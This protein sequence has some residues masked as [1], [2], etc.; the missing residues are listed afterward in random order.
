MK[1][2]DGAVH[3]PKAG[4]EKVE[5]AA[6]AGTV[7]PRKKHRVL[8]RLGIALLVLICLLGVVRLALPSFVRDY[9]NRTLDRNPLYSGTIGPVQIHLWRGAYSIHDVQISKTSGNVPV[10]FFAASRI[11]FAIQWNALLHRKLVG[12]LLMEQPE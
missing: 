2:S 7:A 1:E 8:R 3:P 6:R 9:V 5:P 12:R 11:D 10:P 4:G